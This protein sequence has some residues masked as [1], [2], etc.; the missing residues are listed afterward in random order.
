MMSFS[1]IFQSR[2][3]SVRNAPRVDLTVKSLLWNVV[4]GPLEASISATGGKLELWELVEFLRCPV[5]IVDERAEPLWWGFVNEV[6]VNTGIEMGLSLASMANRIAVAYSYV[7]PG[8][9][10]VGQRK[11]TSWVED[12]ISIATYGYKELLSSQ[13]GLTDE[14][15]EALRNALLASKRFPQ[16][17]I[18]PGQASKTQG[19]T[20][21]CRGWFDTLSWRHYRNTGTANK[22]TTEQITAIVNS[23]GQFLRGTIV[24]DISGISSSEYRAGDM[25]AKREIEALLAVGTTNGR[26]LL[27]TVNQ[28]RWLVIDEEPEPDIASVLLRS[29]GRL[30]NAKTGA[31]MRKPPVGQWVYLQDLIPPSVDLSRVL[32]PSLQ[33]VEGASWN[34]QY[35]L[36]L[37]FRGQPAVED[38]LKVLQ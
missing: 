18:T 6:R 12:A 7:K 28:D 13:A 8:T 38:T 4:G 23:S 21:Y 22:L 30:V 2:D 19:A 25:N 33:F 14:A 29:D 26:R 3:F 24:H 37:Q 5:I 20:L 1:V 9:T 27:A 31:E 34:T 10:S 16:G 32:D 17:V 36:R 15:A 11:T 35:G